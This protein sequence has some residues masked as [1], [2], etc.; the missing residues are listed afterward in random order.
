MRAPKVKAQAANAFYWVSALGSFFDYGY[1]TI[2]MLRLAPFGECSATLEQR[3]LS[4]IKTVKPDGPYGQLLSDNS[5]HSEYQSNALGPTEKC[6]SGAEE[7]NNEASDFDSRAPDF[8]DSS[9][10]AAGRNGTNAM[11]RPYIEWRFPRPR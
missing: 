4:Q 7:K 8:C 2:E 9:V 11:S 1:Q 3:S 6:K 5:T 10:R